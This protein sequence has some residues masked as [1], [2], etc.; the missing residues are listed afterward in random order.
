MVVPC[1][2]SVLSLHINI[3]STDH[4]VMLSMHHANQMLIS[5]VSCCRIMKLNCHIILF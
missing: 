4:I 3:L 2:M 5:I 1:A